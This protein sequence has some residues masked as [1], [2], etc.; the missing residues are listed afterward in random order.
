MCYYSDKGGDALLYNNSLIIVLDN[1]KVL[2]NL[3]R[4]KSYHELSIKTGIPTSTISSWYSHYRPKSIY[5]S[6]KT[7]DR[8]CDAFQIHTSDLFISE[9]KFEHDYTEKNNTM[10]CFRTNFNIICLEKGYSSID[11][12][13]DLFCEYPS[14]STSSARERYYSYFR[15]INGRNIPIDQ[16]DVLANRLDVSTNKLIT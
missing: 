1:I 12:K 3:N 2:R 6:L 14:Y 13:I 9:S 16:L 11:S 8:L 7:L 4:L 10:N 5:P 15:K